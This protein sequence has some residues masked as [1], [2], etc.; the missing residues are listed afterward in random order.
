MLHVGTART[1]LFNYIF[2]KKTGGLFILRVEDTDKERSEKK[3]ENDIIESLEWLGI[4]YDEFHRQSERTAIYKKEISRLLSEKKAFWCHHTKEKLEREKNEQ[5]SKGEAPRHFC[6]HKNSEL[7]QKKG[8]VIRIQ[9]TEEVVVFEDKVHG[10][11]EVGGNT[12]GDIA[13]A[14]NEE[15]PLYNFAVV[16]DDYDM[17]ISH[18]IR[19]DDHIS[20]T[21]KQILIQ[22]SLGIKTPPVYA[23]L[24]LIL[25]SDRTK[26]SKRHGASSV[27]EYKKT[28]YL[29]DAFVNFMAFLGWNPK[30]EREVLN[31]KDIIENFSLEQLQKSPAVFNIEKLNWY[32]KQYIKKLSVENLAG[33]LMEFLPK[34]LSD[35]SASD[36]ELWIKITRLEQDR[37]TLLSDINDGV[38]IFLEKPEPDKKMLLWKNE[39]AEN[40]AIILDKIIKLLSNLNPSDFSAENIKKSVWDFAEEKGRGNVLWPMRVALTGK[41]KSPDPFSVAAVI[42]KDETI[43]RLDASKKILEN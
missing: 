24:P 34:N 6:E 40:S 4:T 10:K 27:T 39:T 7:G 19:G 42:G 35:K 28:G 16:V 5:M 43:K 1:A 20:N 2:A 38:E 13:I 41:E 32:N 3:F 18:V 12:L 14:K 9:G 33:K 25:G 15:N 23:H 26:L 30:D 37:L 36:R 31:I 8:E 29:S 22:R 11:I 21:P 17:E